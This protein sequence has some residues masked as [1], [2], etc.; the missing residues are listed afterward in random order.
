MHITRESALTVAANL[1]SGDIAPDWRYNEYMRGQV[2]TLADLFGSPFEDE[3][4]WEEVKDWYTE[5]IQRHSQ[6]PYYWM[7]ADPDDG[8]PQ[9]YGDSTAAIIDPRSDGVVLYC[10]IDNAK[11]LTITLNKGR[12]Y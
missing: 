6:S 7:T 11:E 4:D 12:G 8:H 10:H 5:E 3:R 1:W 9:V 2:E